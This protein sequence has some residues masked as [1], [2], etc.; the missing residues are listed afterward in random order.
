METQEILD[1]HYAVHKNTSLLDILI[2][3]EKSMD[4]MGV[5]TYKNW[6]EGEVV[7]GPKVGR[8]WVDITLMYPREMMPDPAGGQRLI[9]YDCKVYYKKDYYLAPRRVKTPGDFKPGTKKP[10]VDEVPVWLVTIKMPK[11]LLDNFDLETDADTEA[12][13][14]AKDEGITDETTITSEE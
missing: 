9:G 1:N 5:Y 8:Y 7:E 13:D 12:Q 10:Q 6:M 14:K 11:R 2:E 4:E 3:F